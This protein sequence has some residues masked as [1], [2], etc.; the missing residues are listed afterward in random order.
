MSEYFPELK[1][2]GGGLKVELDLSTVIMQ[3]RQ[4]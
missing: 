2:L 3:Q 4:I 1:P